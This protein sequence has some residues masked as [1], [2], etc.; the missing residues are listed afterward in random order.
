MIPGGMGDSRTTETRTGPGATARA[1]TAA[2]RDMVDSLREQLARQDEQLVERDE[3]LAERDQRIAELRDEITLL[4]DEIRALKNLPKRPRMKPSGMAAAAEAADAAKSGTTDGKG[5]GR[6][7]RKGKKPRGPRRRHPKAVR[8]DVRVELEAVPDGAVFRGYETRTVRDI[9]FRAEE[10]RVQ[11][12]VWETPDGRRHVAPMP[13][14]LV[15]GREQYGLGVKAFVLNAHPPG[16]V[17]GEPHHGAPQRRRAGHL[18]ADGPA[19][20]HRGRGRAG[21]RGAGDPEGRPGQCLLGRRR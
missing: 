12:A 10:V 2:L 20:A 7:D 8:R 17:N 18:E 4:R 6:K 13:G 9:L 1:E 19:D 14:G 16:P 21:H 11:R 3:Q 5:K 15:S